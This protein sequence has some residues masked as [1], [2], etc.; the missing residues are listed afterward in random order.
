M[1][2]PVINAIWVGSDLGQV[3]TAC[4]RSFL[5]HGHRV[6]LHCYDPPKDT[7][8]DIEIADAEEL[9]PEDHITRHHEAKN[10]ALLSDLFRYEILRA[11]LGL[12]VD[13]DVY[14]L[15]PIED[16]DYIFGWQS[17]RSINSAVLK[18]PTHCPVLSEL[19]AIKD[20]PYFEPP[21]RK[22]RR[23]TLE[24]LR[25][26]AP[27]VPLEDLPRGTAGPIAL[28]FY[29]MKHGIDR[30]ASPIDRFYPLHWHNVPLLLDPA[31]SLRELTTH[32]TDAIHLYRYRHDPLIREGV[33]EGSPLWE[34]VCES[35]VR[36]DA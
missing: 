10:F 21:W 5:R 14:C 11:G 7:P 4:L 30:W 28:T 25:G 29:A 8:E 19:C 27:P 6:I 18:L 13:C 23:R 33:P 34:V 31:L 22:V 35:C 9:L 15:R 3:H 2:L 20:N 1:K 12:Y 32:R 26:P 24:W 16:A 36:A 17:S